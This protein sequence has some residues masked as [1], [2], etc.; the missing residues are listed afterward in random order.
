MGIAPW[1]IH[2]LFSKIEGF[3]NGIEFG[4]KI[5]ICEVYMEQVCDLLTYRTGLKLYED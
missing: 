5:G 1:M 4:I 3:S 2:N